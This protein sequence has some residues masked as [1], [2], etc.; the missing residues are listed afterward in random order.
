MRDTHKVVSP[1]D[2]GDFVSREELLNGLEGFEYMGGETGGI[3][4]TMVML[5]LDAK[6]GRTRE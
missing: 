3:R 1:C 6:G 5:G 2:G 4:S